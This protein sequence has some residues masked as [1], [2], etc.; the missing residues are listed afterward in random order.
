M[1]IRIGLVGTDLGRVR[2]RVG[3]SLTLLLA[4][5]NLP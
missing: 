5:K 4:L 3:V 1:G 2:S